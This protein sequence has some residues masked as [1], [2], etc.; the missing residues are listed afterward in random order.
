MLDLSLAV[1]PF[2][3]LFLITN[4][5]SFEVGRPTL[6]AS[7]EFLV[8]STISTSFYT[9]SAVIC[10]GIFQAAVGMV[11]SVVE[12][13]HATNASSSYLS[14]VRSSIARFIAGRSKALDWHAK[15]EYRVPSWRVGGD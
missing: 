13:L 3:R 12:G 7:A 11:L 15:G 9:H 5:L 14:T 1:F 4:L 10:C 6:A 8:N 2:D